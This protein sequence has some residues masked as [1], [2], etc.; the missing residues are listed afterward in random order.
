[1]S[2]NTKDNER[3]LMRVAVAR[4]RYP[5]ASTTSPLRFRLSVARARIFS[6]TAV[7]VTR[8]KTRTSFFWP[9]RWARS[10]ACASIMGFQSLSKRITVSAVARFRPSPPARVLSR[11]MK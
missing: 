3:V 1:M 11:K 5:P 9:M 7:L 6:S 10:C 2:N 4:M 8:R